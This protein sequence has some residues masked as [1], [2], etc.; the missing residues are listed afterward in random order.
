MSDS[1]TLPP[2]SGEDTACPKCGYDQAR[3]TYRAPRPRS[4][5]EWNDQTTTRGPLPERL[6]RNCSRC[7]YAWDEALDP[8]TPANSV[9]P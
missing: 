3:T 4:L 9:K 2:Y 6:Q 1:G 8:P 5:W 7:D